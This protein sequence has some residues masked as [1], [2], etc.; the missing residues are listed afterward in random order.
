MAFVVLVIETPKDSIAEL[1]SKIQR[2]GK[3]HEAVVQAR[4]YLDGILAGCTDSS[5][6]ITSRDTDPSVST[7]GSGS[8]QESYNLK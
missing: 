1:N 5:V 8:E 3:P 2:P 7:S 4:N 6:Q